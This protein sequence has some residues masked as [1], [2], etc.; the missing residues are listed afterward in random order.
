MP[1]IPALGSL[2]QEDHELQGSPGYIR[3]T[4]SPKT[5]VIFSSTVHW[6]SFEIIFSLKAKGILSS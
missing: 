1:I 2:K 4:L 3:E 6:K 5:K